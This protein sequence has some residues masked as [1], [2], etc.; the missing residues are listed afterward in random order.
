M[1]QQ[2][3]SGAAAE[4]NFSMTNASGAVTSHS[5]STGH[6]KVCLPGGTYVDATVGNIVSKGLGLWALRL[7]TGETATLGTVFVKTNVSGVF[8]NAQN[9][10]DEIVPVGSGGPSAATIAAAV[11][12]YTIEGSSSAQTYYRRMAAVLFGKLERVG[13]LRKY[14]D[15]ATGLIDRVIVTVGGAGRTATTYND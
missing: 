11:W 3:A 6:L 1:I 9:F 13:A 4:V 14:K 12:A 8:E 2:G 5:F 10:S 15:V 7:T